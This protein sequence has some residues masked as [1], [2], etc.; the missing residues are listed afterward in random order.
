VERKSNLS[1]ID[2]RYEKYVEKL[3]KIEI[4]SML[5]IQITG[6]TNNRKLK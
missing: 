4:K 5:G 1:P 6:K 2:S 3:K